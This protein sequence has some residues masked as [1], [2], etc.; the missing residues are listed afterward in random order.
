MAI[1]QHYLNFHLKAPFFTLN[2]FGPKTK[3]IWMV[4]H[5]Y[6][7]LVKYF[8]RKFEKLDAEENYLVFPQGLHK[9]YLEGHQRVGAS[10]MTKDER[11]NDI[12]NQFAYLDTIVE[13]TIPKNFDAEIIFF[14]FSQ[15]ASTISRYLH[16]S[17]FPISKLVLWSGSFPPEYV[18]GDFGFLPENT[19]IHYFY[20]DDDEFYDEKKFLQEV[21]NLELVFER[22]ITVSAFQGKHLILPEVIEIDLKF[23]S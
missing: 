8:S 11:L 17:R 10:W 3:R 6:G 1:E 23:C 2:D 18:K 21:E 12:Q 20:G 13:S 4:C 16:H 7:Q 22:D 15:G 9:F 5:G 14:G 19:T